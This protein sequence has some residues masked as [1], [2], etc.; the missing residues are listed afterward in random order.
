MKKTENQNLA[1]IF[2]ALSDESRIEIIRML[3]EKSLCVK[4]LVRRLRISQPAVSQ[5]LRVLREAGLIRGEKKGY[6]VHYSTYPS[7]AEDL[8]RALVGV[9]NEPQS[10]R[11]AI[12]RDARG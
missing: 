12:R 4:A 6:W 2:K 5:H 7:I 1:R 8:K 11:S 9:L 10:R 3:S